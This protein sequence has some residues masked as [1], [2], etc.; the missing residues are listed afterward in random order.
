MKLHFLGTAGYHPSENR[1]TSCVMLPELGIILDAGSGF[2]RV[3]EH[4]ATPE[5]HVFLS[6]AHLDHSLGLTFIF[7]VLHDRPVKQ[8]VVHGEAAKLEALQEHLFS[9]LLFPVKPPLVFR[10]LDGDVA[11]IGETELISFPLE[12]PGG[13]V[14]FRI[15]HQGNSIGYVTDTTADSEASY[16]EKIRGVDLLIHECYFPDGHESRASLIGHSCTS[17]VVQVAQQAQ[18]KRVMLVHINPLD[19]S[20]DPIGLESARKSFANL[21]IATDRQVIDI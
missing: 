12:H 7:D 16:V 14:G 9:P 5:L 1:H 11:R 3:R 20:E 15:N 6:H 18:A 19:E 17:Q 4:I 2:F 10:P 21:E 13:S 8:V